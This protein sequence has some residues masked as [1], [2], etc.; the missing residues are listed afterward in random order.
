[1][2]Q[3]IA[4]DKATVKSKA[5]FNEMYQ[6]DQVTMSLYHLQ[7]YTIWSA[8]NHIEKAGIKCLNLHAHMRKLVT[9]HG[10]NELAKD[11]Q[12]LYDCGYFKPGTNGEI[13]AAIK[14]ITEDLRPQFISLIEGFDI[15]DNTLNSAIGN[16]FGDIY[17]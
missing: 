17:E 5:L 16:S 15:T 13:I 14:R 12:V 7:Y 8:H 6:Q 10:L 4:K 1:M 11:S 9:L 3:G 2:V